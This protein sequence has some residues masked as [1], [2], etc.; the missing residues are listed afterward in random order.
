MEQT[1]L[2]TQEFIREMETLMDSHE[3]K[4]ALQGLNGAARGRNEEDP[5]G[6]TGGSI[7]RNK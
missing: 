2:S 3:I 5:G 1:E 7:R 6:S 4:E